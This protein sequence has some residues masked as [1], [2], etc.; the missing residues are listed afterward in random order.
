MNPLRSLG[1]ILLLTS[2]LA[3]GCAPQ[4]DAGSPQKA[5]KAGEG[6]LPAPKPAAVVPTKAA[7]QR[8]A[9]AEELPRPWPWVI[10]DEDEFEG[11][12]WTFWP[13]AGPKR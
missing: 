4:G 6:T 3:G 5:R 8:T 10:E 7:P 1:W 11:E 2:W 13:L 9:A 12:G